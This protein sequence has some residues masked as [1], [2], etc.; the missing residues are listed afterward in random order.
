M[1]RQAGQDL[2]LATVLAALAVF[3]LID[4]GTAA[5]TNIVRGGQVTHATLPM[6]YAGL[7]LFL[8]SLLA[9]KAL[10]RLRQPDT[11]EPAFSLAPGVWLRIAGTL[12]TLL[13]Y[14]LLLK[15]PVPFVVLTGGFLALLFVLYGHRSLLQVGLVAIIGA[16]ALDALFIRILHLPI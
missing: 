10:F 16:V 15:S 7:L 9:A 5:T 13:A 6:L 12:V 2:A 4:M 1:N 8:T 11:G 3:V 14:V